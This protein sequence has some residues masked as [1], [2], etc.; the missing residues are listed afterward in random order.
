MLSGAS[1]DH[2]WQVECIDLL[3][4]AL[5][6]Y[7]WVLTGIHSHSYFRFACLVTEGKF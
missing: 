5:C 6:E 3:P 4:A 2:S 1:L 7:L